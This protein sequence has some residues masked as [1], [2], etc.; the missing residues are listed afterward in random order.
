MTNQQEQGDNARFCCQECKYMGKTIKTH[1]QTSNSQIECVK[2]G[3][4][5]WLGE[6]CLDYIIGSDVLEE[7]A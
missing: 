7:T 6:V 4:E 3:I 5:R 1:P 2:Y